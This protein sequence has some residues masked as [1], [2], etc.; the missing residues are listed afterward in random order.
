MNFLIFFGLMFLA[1]TVILGLVAAFAVAFDYIN[2][3][4]G[5]PLAALFFLVVVS[6]FIS[7][8]AYNEVMEEIEKESVAEEAE[9]GEG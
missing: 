4:H 5:L 6:L 3:R 7:T 8:L 2:E 1:I 9:K